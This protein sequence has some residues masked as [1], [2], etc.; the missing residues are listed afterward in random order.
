MLYMQRESRK[1]PRFSK[2]YKK[3]N[4]YNYID[5]FAKLH[6][7]DTLNTKLTLHKQKRLGYTEC[8]W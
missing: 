5:R 4:I 2:I 6:E 8:V 3:S 1:L 7:K